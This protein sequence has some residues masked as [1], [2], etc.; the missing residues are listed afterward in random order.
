MINLND[1]R[2]LICFIIGERSITESIISA[3]SK[4]FERDV[5]YEVVESEIRVE[6]KIITLPSEH[7]LDENDPKSENEEKSESEEQSENEEI[8]QEGEEI[9]QK[10]EELSQKDE[11]IPQEDEE[12]IIVDSNSSSISEENLQTETQ[13]E[14]IEVHENNDVGKEEAII[15]PPPDYIFKWV[16]QD[17]KKYGIIR[18]SLQ[19]VIQC[20]K[21]PITIFHPSVL[22][23]AIE[24]FH[25]IYR[26]CVFEILGGENWETEQNVKQKCNDLGISW[27]ELQYQNT[28][29]IVNQLIRLLTGEEDS[30]QILLQNKEPSF[31]LK[32]YVNQSEYI[33]N[34]VYPILLP[35]LEELLRNVQIYSKIKEQKEKEKLEKEKLNE[36]KRID[37]ELKNDETKEDNHEQK[38]DENVESK[39][40]TNEEQMAPVE[41]EQSTQLSKEELNAPK[42]QSLNTEQDDVIVNEENLDE[43]QIISPTKSNKSLSED[44]AMN[45]EESFNQYEEEQRRIRDD[46]EESS[47]KIV[48]NPIIWIAEQLKLKSANKN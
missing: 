9:E 41:T 43:I 33:K 35:I 7:E 37:E 48:E 2:T 29:N 25:P 21:N 15:Y 1:S 22:E 36:K 17:G 42:E 12:N 34:N 18:S 24:K 5:Q 31:Y 40:E 14:N 32:P 16:E 27:I 10:E 13:E 38:E 28:E 26:I 4:K 8:S 11:E 45:E 3:L 39:H 23:E 20:G 6:P 44:E 46:L 19:K 47:R 30:I